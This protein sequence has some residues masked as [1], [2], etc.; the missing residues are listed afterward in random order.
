MQNEIEQRADIV[1]PEIERGGQDNQTDSGNA[2]IKTEDDKLLDRGVKSAGSES[3]KGEN[4]SAENG[5]YRFRDDAEVKHTHT[6]RGQ[7]LTGTSSIMDILSKPLH[8]WAVG[9]SLGKLGYQKEK[10]RQHKIPE[11]VTAKPL[12]GG[13]YQI[14]REYR[15]KKAEEGLAIIKQLNA[16]QY[17]NLL[18]VAYKA[19]TAE[20]KDAATKGTNRHALCEDYIKAWMSG[21]ELP[22][23]PEIKSFTDWAEKNVERFLWS[24]MHCYSEKHWLGGITDAGFVDKQGKLSILDFKSSAEAYY[25]NHIQ[26]AGYD[27]QISENGGYTKDGQKIFEL[28]DKKVDYYTIFPFGA[29]NPQPHFRYDVDKMREGFLAALKL[30]RGINNFA[31][32]P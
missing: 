9:V 6:L 2:T 17:L 22:H 31:T 8:W 13:Y 11:G 14:P 30:Y 1:Y 29:K 7:L 19:H 10:E 26:V 20:S 16:E 21:K 3:A 4:G 5:A 27:I 24:E 28:G 18:D 12:Y 23:N 32:K 15:L 25:G